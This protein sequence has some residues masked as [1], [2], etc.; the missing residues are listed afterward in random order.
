MST[1]HELQDHSLSLPQGL[2]DRG[3]LTPVPLACLCF[4]FV[5]CAVRM[6]PLPEPVF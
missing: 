1:P 6:T 5:I 3:V 4:C 2:A